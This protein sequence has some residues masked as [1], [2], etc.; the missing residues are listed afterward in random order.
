MANVKLGGKTDNKLNHIYIYISYCAARHH[1]FPY[2]F[3]TNV[4]SLKTFARMYPT[5]NVGSLTKGQTVIWHKKKKKKE[6]KCRKSK[7]SPNSVHCGNM[8]SVLIIHYMFQPTWPSS[9]KYKNM[10]STWDVNYNCKKKFNKIFKIK[11]IIHKDSYFLNFI[12][13]IYPKGM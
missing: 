12:Y 11:G 10:Q 13:S 9:G 7:F 8:K 5:R 3:A 4:L 6:G 2:S 1:K